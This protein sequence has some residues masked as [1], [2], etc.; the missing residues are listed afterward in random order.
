MKKRFLPLAL[1]LLMCLSL[2]PMTALAAASIP[3]VEELKTTSLNVAYEDEND[4]YEG[5][6]VT[7][8]K[9]AALQAFQTQMYE[10][11]NALGLEY[12]NVVLQLDWSLDSRNDW[13]YGANWDK[14]Q[15]Q[16]SNYYEYIKIGSDYRDQADD[17]YIMDIGRVDQAEGAS[18]WDGEG[19]WK[20]VVG[21]KCEIDDSFY[22]VYYINFD[23]HTIYLRARYVLE[24]RETGADDYS[25]VC[26]DWSNVVAF[27]KDNVP[28]VRPTELPAPVVSDLKLSEETHNG[29]PIIEYTI[30]HTQETL[31]QAAAALANGANIILVGEA[32]IN[33]AGWQ[34][35]ST[36]Q[37]L[38]TGPTSSILGSY[39]EALDN[40]DYVQFRCRYCYYVSVS[41]NFY[42][43]YSNI[44]EFGAPA[45]GNASDWA[46][47]E[48]Q[49]AADLGLIPDCLEGAD[50]TQDI[51][52][53]EFAAVAVKAYEALSGTAAIPIVNNPFTDC[54]DVEVLKAYNI[55]AVNG[56]SATT[57]DPDEL[58]NR[59][60][61][62]TMLTRVFKRI[63][64]AGWTLETDGQ[65][66]LT[67]TQPAAFADDANI[68]AW[69][70]DSVYF[71]SANGI[72]NGVGNNLFA[73]KNVT[74]AEQAEGYANAT[75]EQ[76][77]LIAVRMVQNLG[78]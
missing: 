32:N 42:G 26:G 62:A 19:G 44:I 21:D 48:L 20:Q 68:S 45:W 27:G 38:I 4:K 13:K 18:W 15:A 30:V 29:T 16:N 54:N 69:A 66:S 41:D 60:Q 11:R 3:S 59:E 2:M 49:E 39:A 76:A 46:T 8:G 74:T 6:K 23:N 50:L 17:A 61:A 37:T 53:A 35:I 36:N 51:T 43:P 7:V 71:M 55:G 77:L 1:A 75:R 57:F 31:D 47:E 5:L 14:I 78:N 33:N 63:T 56:T 10:D 25:Y 73:P 34:E 64:L 67:Y 22:T 9:T 70:K 12:G 72:I 28:Y 58:L 65:F 52:R 40:A 24:Y